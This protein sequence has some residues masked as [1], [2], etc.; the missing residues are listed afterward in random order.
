MKYFITIIYLL[1]SFN[2]FSQYPS[3]SFAYYLKNLPTQPN[4]YY[5]DGELKN[6]NTSIKLDVS[7]FQQCADAVIRLHAEWLWSQKRYKDI[8]YNFSNGFTADYVR[9]AN[10]ERIKVKNNKVLWVKTHEPDYSYDTFRK[11]L[12]IVFQ[13]ANT[14]SLEKELV[15]V[16]DGKLKPGDV[17]I[18]GGYPGHAVIFTEVEY[19]DSGMIFKCAQSWMPAQSIEFIQAF[20]SAIKKI[21]IKIKLVLLI[22]LMYGVDF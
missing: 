13:Y 21:L 16:T 8:H 1:L 9:F 10:G 5:W 2:C 17:F 7:Q 12:E 4:T 6:N 15:P 22:I 19:E 20:G 3:N 14:A 11:Y 18:I